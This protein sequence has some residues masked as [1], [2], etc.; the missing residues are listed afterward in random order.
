MGSVAAAVFVTLSAPTERDAEAHP[1]DG[2]CLAA[3]DIISFFRVGVK[4][5][6]GSQDEKAS[7]FMGPR[8]PGVHEKV[9]QAFAQASLK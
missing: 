2:T 3:S 9:H 6:Y 8:C 1:A 5:P 7:F 4:H